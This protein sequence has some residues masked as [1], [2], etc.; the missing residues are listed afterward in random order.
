MTK[1]PQCLFSVIC[2]AISL[3]ACSPA[4]KN[5]GLS[6]TESATQLA[7]VASES[8]KL[9]AFFAAS[10]Q[11]DLE[12]SPMTQSRLGLKWD[13]GKWDDVSPQADQMRRD[14]QL[15]HASI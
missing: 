5:N 4:P 2:I 13:Y 10:F 3:S 14:L 1:I 8:E 12:M 15:H 11:Q 9:A 7:E 6:E